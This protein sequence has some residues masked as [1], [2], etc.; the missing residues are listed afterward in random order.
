MTLLIHCVM[1]ADHESSQ[2]I[3]WNIMHHE[4]NHSFYAI[5]EI[6]GKKKNVYDLHPYHN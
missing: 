2:T 1:Y 5:T 6:V 3:Y 4:F